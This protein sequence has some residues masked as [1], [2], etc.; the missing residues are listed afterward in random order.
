MIDSDNDGGWDYTFDDYWGLASY[1][2][3]E[4]Q[5]DTPGFGPL[6]VFLAI[7][8]ILFWRWKKK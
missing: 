4:E 8:L 2:T 7:A 5:E 1:Q 6:F 3:D